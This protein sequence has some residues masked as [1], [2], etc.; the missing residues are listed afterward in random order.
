MS[1]QFIP[2]HPITIDL[3]PTNLTKDVKWNTIDQ[4]GT[5]HSTDGI[6]P[7]DSIVQIPNIMSEIKEITDPEGLNPA[8]GPVQNNEIEGNENDGLLEGGSYIVGS[9][10]RDY[11]ISNTTPGSI[12]SFNVL[13]QTNDFMAQ[14][15]ANGGI[16]MSFVIHG[17]SD[18]TQQWA[19]YNYIEGDNTDPSGGEFNTLFYKTSSWIAFNSKES[20]DRS[21]TSSQTRFRKSF[22]HVYIPF[23]LE[24]IRGYSQLRGVSGDINRLEI[25]TLATQAGGPDRIYNFALANLPSILSD[26]TLTINERFNGLGTMPFTGYQ[27]SSPFVVKASYGLGTAPSGQPQDIQYAATGVQAKFNAFTSP[28]TTNG[29]T[30]AIDIKNSSD[31]TFF[32]GVVNSSIV[33][34]PPTGQVGRVGAY[35]NGLPNGILEAPGYN[36]V[37]YYSTQIQQQIYPPHYMRIYNGVTHG[38][39]NYLEYFVPYATPITNPGGMPGQH[40]PG[41]S[42]LFGRSSSA[43]GVTINLGL[44]AGDYIKISGSISNN[45]VYQVVSVQNGIPPIIGGDI[46]NFQDITD[47][48]YNRV[49]WYPDLDVSGL[50]FPAT[51]EL[52]LQPRVQYLELSPQIVP[53]DCFGMNVTIEVVTKKPILHIKYRVKN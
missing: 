33:N 31:T 34:Y 15:R 10:N 50:P 52:A 36:L 46:P 29:L 40:P 23:R 11:T 4:A 18:G 20:I 3:A 1:E 7:D 32:T 5:Q 38:T 30:F 2:N 43:D 28:S 42:R 17:K 6:Y 19:E 9:G 47:Y 35:Q 53:E 12:N 45:G 14:A 48:A 24:N 16:T 26:T 37:D 27:F 13:N 44:V 8:I 22:G 21:I 49:L 25:R 51:S 41:G 39:K